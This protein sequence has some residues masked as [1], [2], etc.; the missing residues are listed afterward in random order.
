MAGL[1][2]F[3]PTTSR[4]TVEVTV[5]FTTGRPPRADVKAPSDSVAKSASQVQILIRRGAKTT[6]PS[7]GVSGEGLTSCEAIASGLLAAPA[8]S[9]GLH[10]AV[11]AQAMS[12]REQRGR[13]PIFDGQ[14]HFD[15]FP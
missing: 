10:S 1:V 13:I 9:G 15:R 12:L 6:R 14:L 8:I 7:R 2:G 5:F 4:G 3:E 11:R